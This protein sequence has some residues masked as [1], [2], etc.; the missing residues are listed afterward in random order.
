MSFLSRATHFFYPFLLCLGPEQIKSVWGVVVDSC[1]TRN[2]PLVYVGV[3]EQ[4][5]FTP[6]L[7]DTRIS[8]GPCSTSSFSF[9]SKLSEKKGWSSAFFS[10]IQQSGA[11]HAKADRFGVLAAFRCSSPFPFIAGHTT[12]RDESS[13]LARFFSFFWI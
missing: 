3:Q 8:A 1:K 7:L 6:S 9:L 11:V 10:L 12:G 4:L 13:M 5:I 2:T